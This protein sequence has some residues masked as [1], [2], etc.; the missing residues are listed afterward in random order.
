MDLRTVR[1]IY[2]NIDNFIFFKKNEVRKQ[3]TEN[4][5]QKT[6]NRKQKI[7]HYVRKL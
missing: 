1:M 3:K 7:G 6:E 4:R 5:K 2:E